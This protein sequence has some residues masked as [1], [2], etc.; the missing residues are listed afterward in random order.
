M[1]LEINVLNRIFCKRN[2]IQPKYHWVEIKY[3]DAIQDRGRQ[4]FCLRDNAFSQY[5]LSY[6]SAAVARRRELKRLYIY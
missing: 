2:M 5:M 3:L 4:L 6:A 1:V